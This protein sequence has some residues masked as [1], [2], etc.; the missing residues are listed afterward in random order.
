VKGD[1]KV[2]AKPLSDGSVAIGLF[3]NTDE[4]AELSFSLDDLGLSGP[5]PIRDLWAKKDLGDV[6]AGYKETIAPH[7]AKLFKIG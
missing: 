2:L 5:K 6:S 1:V 4:D 3:N 7:C